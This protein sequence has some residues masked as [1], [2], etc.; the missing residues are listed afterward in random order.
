MSLDIPGKGFLSSEFDEDQTILAFALGKAW[1]NV[2]LLIAIQHV[3]CTGCHNRT[4]GPLKAKEDAWK[5]HCAWG[6]F[7]PVH[8]SSEPQ[9]LHGITDVSNST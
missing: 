3:A 7:R 4:L 5:Q 6:P 8:E 9:I 1:A 2:H